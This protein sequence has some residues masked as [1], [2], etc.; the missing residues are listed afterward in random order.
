MKTLTTAEPGPV[1][2]TMPRHSLTLLIPG[3]NE[4]AHIG[5][6]LDALA[7]QPFVRALG[8]AFSVVVVDDG[9]TD[10]MASVAQ[11]RAPL[12][13]DLRVHRLETNQGKGLAVRAGLALASTDFVAFVDGDDT[14]DLGCLETLYRALEQGADVAIG[15][16][17]L[18]ES[19]FLLPA[20]A[21]PYIHFR[22]FV[23][24]GLNV[25]VRALTRLEVL[26]TQ[27]GFK[28]FRREAAAHC[29]SKI[30][31]GGFIFD[32]EVLLAAA[33]AGYR[34]QP[35]PMHLRYAAPEP[36][37][38][39]LSLSARVSASLVRVLLNDRAGRYGPER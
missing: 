25:L 7:A 28:M 8:P 31:V 23:G 16:R 32:I 15:D 9:S 37:R 1:E 10:G 36:T 4:A 33:H 38:E 30:R 6:M 18:P 17:R 12:F 19:N 26:D 34:I 21:V 20:T 13:H 11:G 24:E 14:F 2:G 39:V 27:C 5:P 35:V 22:T 3:L 29:F